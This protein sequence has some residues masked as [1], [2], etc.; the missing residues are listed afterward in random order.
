MDRERIIDMEKFTTDYLE[1][2]LEP[3]EMLTEIQVPTL[4]CY[5]GVAHEKLMVMRGD[6]WDSSVHN[7]VSRR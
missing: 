4:S 6:S 1:V 2:A 3:D 7:S 5:T